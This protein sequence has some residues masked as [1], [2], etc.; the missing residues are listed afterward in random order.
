MG[1][2]AVLQPKDCL[3]QR[4]PRDKFISS[5]M[6]SGRRIPNT[7]PKSKSY[8]NPK[9]N[10]NSN[11]NRSDRRKRSSSS[12]NSSNTDNTTTA[13]AAAKNL[14]MGQVKIL[15]RGE[16]LDVLKDEKKS[17][18]TQEVKA[19]VLKDESKFMLESVE[20]KVDDDL[21]EDDDLVL[22][23]TDRLGPE[24]EMVPKQMIKVPD[25]YAGFAFVDS[26]PPSS[27]PLPAFFT[28]K[29]DPTMGLL[30]LLGLNL[31]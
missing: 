11:V 15:K 8:Q 14:V 31:S 9:S 13:A 3:N 25:L 17:S 16:A 18:K 2:V 22:S 1:A 30:R 27:L 20:K 4:L 12:R 24:P 29:S 10:P 5:G 28:K 21:V 7:N 6:K 23:T 26:P 19:T